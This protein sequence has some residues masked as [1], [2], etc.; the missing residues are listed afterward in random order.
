MN[1]YGVVKSIIFISFLFNFFTF[2]AQQIIFSGVIKDSLQSPIVNVNVLA[3]PVSDNLNITFSVSD[4]SGNFRLR[5]VQ[6]QDY[7]IKINHIGF[8]QQIIRLSTKKNDFKKNF[9]L[10]ENINQLD[11]IVINHVIPIVIKK[12]TIIFN[13]DSFI[14][15]KERKLRDV[16]KRLPMVEVDREGN[17][18]VQG[19]R[20]TKMLVENKEFFTGDSK[21]AVNNIPAE[22]IDKIEVLDNYNDVSFLKGL[23]DNNNMAMN[24]IL[25]EDKKNFMFGDI[26]ASVGIKNRH[27]IHPTLYYYSPKTTVNAITNFNNTG[28]K[29]FT[30]KDYLEFEGDISSLLTNAKSYFS[31]L[32]EGFRQ[33]MDNQD[34]IESQNQFGALNLNQTVNSKL[35][36]STYGIWSYM[37][38][39][40][41]TQTINKYNDSNNLIEYRNNK[42]DNYNK[43]GIGKFKLVFKPNND[44]NI[45]LGSF[46]KISEN[47]SLEN[48]ST[49]TNESN[50]N[51]STNIKADNISLKQDIQWHKK[52][53][54]KHTLS[55]VFNY[56]YQKITP[57]TNW[58]TNKTI[59]PEL[60]PMINENVYNIFKIQKTL[61]H[62][63]DLAIKHYWILNQSNHIYFTLGSQVALGNL[64]T[65]EYQKLENGSI[66]SFLDFGFGNNTALS[67]NDMFFGIHYKARKGNIT[68]K[69]GVFYHY[70]NWKINRFS[71][72]TKKTNS[73]LLPELMVKVEFNS[74]KKLKFNYNLK[75]RFPNISQ[76]SDSLTLLNFNSIYK[77]NS[78]LNNELYHQF[79]INFQ[80]F[81]LFKNIFY[82]LNLSYHVKEENIKNII[83]IQ[84]INF[85]ST[86]LL[87]NFEDRILSFGGNLKKGFGKYKVSVKGNL[88]FS[89][90]E[91]PVN[92]QLTS[93]TANTYLFGGLVETNFNNLLHLELGY[94][95]SISN[96]RRGS[97]SIFENDIFSGFL[98]YKFLK[99]F[100]FKADY[101]YES[102]KNNSFGATNSFNVAN[103]SIFYQKE[104]SPLG[105]EI[106]MNNILDIK[107]KQRN[108]FISIS[109]S[110]EKTYI[111]PRMILLKVFYKL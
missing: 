69:P 109:V 62:D 94:T 88:S 25:K 83:L 111:L 16:L 97:T 23:E 68:F 22:V 90:Y 70:N 106:S 64:K 10:S 98:E 89:N 103:A 95:K 5:L 79:R 13:T 3:I 46:M 61:S 37:R 48:I 28:T 54:K 78:Q 85:I 84:D 77:G 99:D 86:P 9:I 11:E 82:N 4:N 57:N 21:M 75:F 43:F 32:N 55:T 12:D 17:V 38:S 93:N 42:G 40:S 87:S 56:H 66:N 31:S 6:N 41:I 20:V 14:S 26:E 58:Q 107:F 76:L 19:K 67:F 100:L 18:I 53:N 7:D 81:S 63:I 24:I 49:I 35:S 101:S 8:K 92:N 71:E 33:F 65:S 73:I 15:G 74:T 59:F 110:E 44:S 29:T 30:F 34:I 96:Y 50:N 108:S 104:Q 45:A 52:F 2:N 105:F 60:I 80:R 51:I 91:N 47:K 72:V 102:Y 27:L 39:K 36:L 1:E